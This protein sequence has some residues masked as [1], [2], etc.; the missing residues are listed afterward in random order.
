M[1]GLGFRVWEVWGLGLR[2]QSLGFTAT[3]LN[4]VDGGISGRQDLRVIAWSNFQQSRKA[5]VK[6]GCE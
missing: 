4:H 1:W 6:L 2:V 5:R 3:D